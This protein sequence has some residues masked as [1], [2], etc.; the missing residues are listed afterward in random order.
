MIR[1][2]LCN[3][4]GNITNDVMH[5]HRPLLTPLMFVSADLHSSSNTFLC[6]S[7]LPPFSAFAVVTIA[8]GRPSHSLT[9]LVA[10]GC[11][12]GFSENHWRSFEISSRLTLRIDVEHGSPYEYPYS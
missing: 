1:I 10:M 11:N 7:T 12:S 5:S 6:T 9:T 4:F 3:W 8:I 2:F